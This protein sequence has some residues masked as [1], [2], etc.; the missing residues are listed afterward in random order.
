MTNRFSEQIRNVRKERNLTLK[1]LSTASGMSVSQLSKLE[2][3]KARLSVETAMALANILQ[4]PVAALLSK[5]A[6]ESRSR[7]SI[8]RAET[9]LKHQQPGMEFEV[10]CSDL[11]D[12]RNVFWRVVVTGQT[13]EAAGGWRRHPGEEFLHI[14]TGILELHT[15][16]YEPVQLGSGDSIL[17]DADMP[18]AYVAIGKDPVTLIMSN[19]VPINGSDG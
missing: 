15:E 17:F 3:G 13:I 10:L 12:K 19:T 18:H 9:G 4:V 2:N 16:H 6:A 8:T 5:P 11:K 14:L 7:R 1:S